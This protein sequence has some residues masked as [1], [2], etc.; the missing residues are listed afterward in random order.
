MHASHQGVCSIADH[1][2]RLL[3]ANVV[4]ATAHSRSSSCRLSVAMGVAATAGE[5]SALPSAAPLTAA[6]TAI[7]TLLSAFPDEF[8]CAKLLRRGHAAEW[9]VVAARVEAAVPPRLRRQVGFQQQ[10]TSEQ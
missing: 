10:P 2:L 4:W 3:L 5:L 9:A 8:E 6:C 1:Q 7:A